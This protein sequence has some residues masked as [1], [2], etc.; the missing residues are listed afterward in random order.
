MVGIPPI[1]MVMNGRWFI[2]ELLLLYHYTNISFFLSERLRPMRNP[3]M[4]CC[5]AMKFP[6]E[7]AIVHVYPLFSDSPVWTVWLNAFQETN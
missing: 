4:L 6:G 7:I 1:E 3:Q 5:S 2:I